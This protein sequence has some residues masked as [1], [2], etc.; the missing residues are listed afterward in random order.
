MLMTSAPLHQ[1]ECFH[2]YVLLI[3]DTPSLYYWC[4]LSTTCTFSYIAPLLF[5]SLL[6]LIT[7]AHLPVLG[8]NFHMYYDVYYRQVITTVF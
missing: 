8:A 2:I 4:L 1:L 5:T 6:I 3:T 7:D